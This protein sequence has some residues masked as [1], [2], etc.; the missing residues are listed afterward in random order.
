MVDL[1]ADIRTLLSDGNPWTLRQI[2]FELDAEDDQVAKLLT[3]ANG[4]EASGPPTHRGYTLADLQDPAVD[5]DDARAM[6]RRQQSILELLAAA[7]EPMSAAAIREALQLTNAQVHQALTPLRKARRVQWTGS[8]TGR[9]YSVPATGTPTKPTAYTTDVWAALPAVMEADCPYTVERLT[10]LVR[11]RLDGR[12]L[13]AGA[14]PEALDRLRLNGVL[15]TDGRWWT[16]PEKPRITKEPDVAKK[17]LDDQAAT[18]RDLLTTHGP[19]KAAQ[20]KD[21]SGLG[22]S[23]V[24]RALNHLKEQGEVENVHSFWTLTGRPT[25]SKPAEAKPDPMARLLDE[26]GYETA[27]EVIAAYQRNE[28][29]IE[30]VARLVGLEVDDGTGN[31]PDVREAVA[32]RLQAAESA[33][34]RDESDALHSGGILSDVCDIAFEDATR[35][36]VHGYEGIRDRIRELVD[37]ANIL[38]EVADALGCGKEHVLETARVKARHAHRWLEVTELCDVPSDDDVLPYLE[39]VDKYADIAVDAAAE[40][41]VPTS[42]L[43]S[44]VH[45]RASPDTEL[46]GLRGWKAGAEWAAGLVAPGLA[47]K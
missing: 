38:D 35:A 25:A 24:Y 3:K 36:E 5:L 39:R 18:V 13:F 40:L 41:G 21:R 29:M 43:V 9:T 16:R 17:T 11:A 44:A 10:E 28:K 1:L 19:M 31:A 22:S 20:V 46:A 8:G 33:A 4:F 14:M 12:P 47:A 27:D 45:D 37:L 34:R 32:R 23:S 15:T 6:E 42:E 30:D 26:L 7:I 2:A